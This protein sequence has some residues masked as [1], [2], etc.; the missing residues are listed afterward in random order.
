MEHKRDTNDDETLKDGVPEAVEDFLQNFVH[1]AGLSRT[2]A[3]FQTE[4]FTRDARSHGRAELERVRGDTELLQREVQAAAEGLARTRRERD[5]HREQ[6]RR[7]AEEK[8]SL[9]GDLRRLR[10]HRDS[11]GPALS[12]LGV[13]HRAALRHRVLLRLGRD[14]DPSQDPSQDPGPEEEEE[15][16]EEPPEQRPPRDSEFPVRPAAPSP[17]Q[18]W[19]KGS[20]RL[21]GS[22]RAHDLPASCVAAHPGE[23]LLAS[24]SDDRSW[25][26]WSLRGLRDDAGVCDVTEDD[27]G[28]LLL[29]GEGHSDWLTACSFH[30]DGSKLA[31]TS[32][33]T[34]LQLWDL[35]R[36]GGGRSVLTLRGHRQPAWG[37]SF[38]SCGDFLASCSADRTA[39]VWDL[40]SHRCR[41]TLRCHAASVNGVCFLPASNLLLT[42]SSDRTVVQWDARMA[43]CTVVMRGHG[44]PCNAVAGSLVTHVVASCDAGGVVHLWDTRKP[45]SP[46]ST[47]DV[48]PAVNHVA[49]SGSGAWLAAA[50]GDGSLRLVEVTP[51]R[52]EELAGHAHGG[53]AQGVAFWGGGT[54]VSAGRDG[55]I[56]VWS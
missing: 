27:V 18:P 49:F 39:K 28:Q 29:T 7:V 14:R 13:Q 33:D 40:C 12:R 50:G 23:P 15:T 4:W 55:R 16:P 42:C 46:V 44:S 11:L 6:S 22:I 5:F 2:L 10:G 41:L 21:R 36:R 24:G 45:E 47:L 56:N 25:R 9:A 54:L 51:W 30:P 43:A 38:H 34:T 17:G 31:T 1:G 26:L 48:G 53:G 19:R 52:V 3:G 32:G 37:C 8:R 35:L 20:L